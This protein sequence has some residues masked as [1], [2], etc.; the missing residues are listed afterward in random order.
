MPAASFWISKKCIS[1]SVPFR[2]V[3]PQTG[4]FPVCGILLL[5]WRKWP[6]CAMNKAVFVDKFLVFGRLNIKKQET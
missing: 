2:E 5:E 1:S 4:L 3:V 6:Y